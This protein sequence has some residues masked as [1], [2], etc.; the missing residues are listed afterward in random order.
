MQKMEKYSFLD[1]CNGNGKLSY[2]AQL[3]SLVL[4][5]PEKEVHR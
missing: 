3:T 5:K 1:N 2:K 4:R